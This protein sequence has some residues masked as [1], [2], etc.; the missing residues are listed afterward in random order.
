MK[1]LLQCSIQW[2]TGTHYTVAHRYTVHSGTPVH[3][4]EWHTGT[5]YTV[6]HRY[7]VY[8]G[9]PVHSIQWHTGTQYTM[10]HRYTVTLNKIATLWYTVV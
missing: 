9:T 3:N 6:A 5:Q 7:T 10:A 1:V 8:S 2:H 4:I